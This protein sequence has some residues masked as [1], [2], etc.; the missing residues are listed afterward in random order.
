MTMCAC[1]IQVYSMDSIPL[2]MPQGAPQ[3][4]NDDVDVTI[5]DYLRIL[6]ATEVSLYVSITVRL[7]VC[8]YMFV[9]GGIPT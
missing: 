9:C 3:T 2:K 1:L 7:R 6:Q 4:V 5:P 8:A